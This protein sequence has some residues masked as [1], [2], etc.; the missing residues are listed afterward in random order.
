M[1]RQSEVLNMNINSL[2][3][4]EKAWERLNTRAEYTELYPIKSDE[5]QTMFR[6]FITSVNDI[7]NDIMRHS[8]FDWEKPFIDWS[9]VEPVYD[10]FKE[11]LT[12]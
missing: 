2:I 10:W 12:Q 9:D 11:C 4:V 5:C 8:G 3:K 7:D 1:L 6:E